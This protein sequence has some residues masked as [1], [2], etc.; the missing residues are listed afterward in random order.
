MPSAIGTMTKAV[1][2]VMMLFSAVY[3]FGVIWRVEKK[4]DTSFKLFLA[5]ILFFIT[6][7]IMTLAGNNLYLA[8]GQDT[9]KILFAL[10]F[11]LGILE[12]R[13]LIRSIDGEK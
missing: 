13:S 5:A 7:E 3:T 10:F 6:A 4:L 9:A 8:A 11:L 12:M 2:I 1:I